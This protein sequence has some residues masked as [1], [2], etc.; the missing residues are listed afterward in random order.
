MNNLYV[1]F[2]F[3]KLISIDSGDHDMLF[4]YIGTEKWIASLNLPIEGPWNPW[5]LGDQVAG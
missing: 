2:M 1:T 5:F 3:L 4:P